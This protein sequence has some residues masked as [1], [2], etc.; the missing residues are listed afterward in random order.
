MGGTE[1]F[2]HGENFTLGLSLLPAFKV[3]TEG[4]R[5]MTSIPFPQNPYIIHCPAARGSIDIMTVLQTGEMTPC[6]DVGNLKCQ[7]KFGNLLTDSPS[8]IMA[9]F[10]ESSKV[11]MIGISKNQAN[12]QSGKSGKWVEEGIPPYCG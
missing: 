3:G 12:L 8:E 10:E 2:A 9:K 11:M 7:P 4:K 1:A 5:S 6:C